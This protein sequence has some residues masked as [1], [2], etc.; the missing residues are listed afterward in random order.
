[1]CGNPVDLDRAI[2]CLHESMAYGWTNAKSGVL[3]GKMLLRRARTQVDFDDAICQFAAGAQREGDNINDRITAVLKWTR[4]ATKSSFPQSQHK[5]TKAYDVAIE[6]LPK[7]FWNGLNASTRLET[8][9]R[10]QTLTSDA[11][12]WQLLHNEG[13][14]PRAIELL[15]QGRSV[16]WTQSL[17]IQ[18]AFD[19]LPETHR[20]RWK[21]TRMANDFSVITSSEKPWPKYPQ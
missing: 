11:A 10:V 16:F 1:M 20:F 18:T 21:L 7:L 13:N 19:E 8:L 17:Q 6:L 15:E 5:A 2:A 4:H 14:G 9:S 12:S 3:L